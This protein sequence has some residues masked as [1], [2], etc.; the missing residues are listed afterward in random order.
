MWLGV[1]SGDAALGT[2][3]WWYGSFTSL[4]DDGRGSRSCSDSGQPG[5]GTSH[6]ATV[7]QGGVGPQTTAPPPQPPVCP[8][9]PCHGGPVVTRVCL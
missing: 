2:P 6:A 3:T 7:I 4:L 1:H 9:Q 5:A 8:V